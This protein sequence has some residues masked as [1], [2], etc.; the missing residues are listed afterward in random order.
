MRWLVDC[1][2]QRRDDKPVLKWEDILE[3]FQ[4][5]IKILGKKLYCVIS[6]LTGNLPA[7]YFQR[8]II[9]H[10]IEQ[11]PWNIFTAK[12]LSIVHVNLP[13]YS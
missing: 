8:F 2:S 9:L 12:L 11:S 13:E 1:T 6:C 7:W 4:N 3:R 5:N 10:N